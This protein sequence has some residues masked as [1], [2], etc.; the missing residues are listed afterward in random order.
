MKSLAKYQVGQNIAKSSTT[1]TQFDRLSKLIKQWEDEVK[2]FDYK[3]G[4]KNR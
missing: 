3:T 2:D 4:L 1:A